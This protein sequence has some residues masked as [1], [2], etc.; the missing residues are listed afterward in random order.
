MNDD[1]E[2][3]LAEMG[4]VV[5]GAFAPAPGDE[6]PSLPGSLR[7]RT[8]VLVGNAGPAMW[9]AYVAQGGPEAA[10]LDSWCEA[11]L[12]PLAA[13]LGAVAHF[14][15]ARPHRPFQRWLRRAGGSFSS[16][17]GIDIH[18][19]YGLWWGLRGALSFRRDL[20]PPPALAA[21][22]GPCEN[23]ADQP[24]LAG[25]PVDAFGG[26]GYDVVSCAA[27]LA[28]P[29]GED[30]MRFA[31]RARSACPVGTAYRHEPE[32]AAFHMSAF[33]AARHAG[34]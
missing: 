3:G 17:I 5:L 20:A 27:H 11:G 33:L 30:C 2:T 26:N 28:G 19:E 15:W 8:L 24:C 10:G 34:G 9:R 7:C 16:P 18:P 6:V 29:R 23:C 25:C 4:L 21:G 1:L 32:Q 31:C 22:A 14:P 12:A 13:R